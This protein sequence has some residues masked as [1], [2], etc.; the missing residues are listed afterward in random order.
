VSTGKR[1]R[2][3]TLGEPV[4]P[5]P[6]PPN[7]RPLP[8]QSDHRPHVNTQILGEWYAALVDTGAAGSFIG[9]H[10]RDKCNRHLR[11]VAPTIQSARMANGQVDT[12]TEAYWISLRI[13]TT[14]IQGKFHHLPHLPSDLV[15]GIDLLRRY[16]FSIDLKEGSASLRPPTAAD[17]VQP[18][19]PQP[20]CQVSDSPP[21]TL[22][23]DE[24]QRLRQFLTEELPLFDSVR[25][26]T[27][28]ARHE[29]RLLHPEPV[30][31]RYRPR[32]PFM[33]GIIDE[34]VD[35]MLAEGVIEPSDSPWSSPI[36]LAKKK[37]GKH[38]FC[39]DF[40]KVNE[41]TR[42]DA[43]PLPFINVILDKLRR[44]RYI[45]TIDL[46]SGYWQVPL[47]PSSKPITAFT[48]PSRG[49]YQ[50]RVMPF[51]LHSAPATFQRLMDRVIGPE[52]DPY[53]FA[54]LDDIVVLGETF[55]QHL[56][57]LQEVF[58]RLRAANLRLNPDKCQFGRRSLTYLGHVVTAAGIRTDPDKVA[59]I[60][61]LATPKTL[62]QLRRFLGMASWYRRFIPD[63]SRIAAPL[64]RLLKKGGR[65]DWTPEQDAAFNTLKDSL[66][67]APVLACPDFG[68]PFVL[69]TDA[70]DTGLGV[71]LTQYVD[72]GDHV[73]AYASRSLTKPEQAYSTTEKECLAVVWG[74]E[75]MRPYLEGYRFTVLTDHQSLKWLQAIKD[76]TGRLARW[77]IFLQQHDFD[78]RYRKGV[79]N[80]VAD[81]LSRQPAA[82]EDETTPEDLFALEGA[83]GC[84]WYNRMRQEVEKDPTVHPD[85][86]IRNERLHRHFWDMSDSTE[87]E[88]SDPWK[89]CVP[90][91]V[92][93]AVLRECH[94]NPTA[95]HL[96]IAKT[97]ARLAL[98]YYWPGM[99]R[100]AAQYV[101]NCPS[102]QR[103]KTPQQQP[104]GKMY[105]TPNRQP[106]ETV[107]T[108][109]VGPLPRSSRGNC[110]VVVMQDRFT[111]WV[112]CRAVRKATARAVTQALYEDVITRFGCP[113]TVISDN[114]T[115]YTGGTFRTLL[116]E[117]GIVH[118]LTPPY[119]PQANPV[120]RTNKTLKTMVAQFCEAD[121]KK[122]DAHLPELMFALNTSRHEST[123]YTPA[124]LNFG[125]ELVVPNAVHR[126][127][128]GNAA[129]DPPADTAADPPADP[130]ADTAADPPA[131]T[132]ADEVNEAADAVHHSERL[133][134]L[135]DTFELVRVNLARAFAKQSKHYNLRH[136]EWRCHLGDRVL[137]RD[138]PLSSGAKGFAAKL[139]P[140]YSGPYTV[141]KVLSPVVYNL[142]SPSGQKILRVHIKDLKPYRTTEPPTDCLTIFRMPN[143]RAPPAP[144]DLPSAKQ[145]RRR[146]Q[147]GQAGLAQAARRAAHQ[148]Q[149][150]LRRTPRTLQD[151]KSRARN[152]P[153]TG[154]TASGE[155][156]LLPPTRPAAS[157][158]WIDGVDRRALPRRTREPSGPGIPMDLT[159]RRRQQD[160]TPPLP[161]PRVSD[162]TP[163]TSTPT[164]PPKAPPTGILPGQA[165]QPADHPPK[166]TIA[167][168]ATTVE[169]ITALPHQACFPP[170]PA[171]GPQ[172]DRSCPGGT[173]PRRP[174]HRKVKRTRTGKRVRQYVRSEGTPQAWD[175]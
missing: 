17:E 82:T 26:L 46:K 105:P 56:Q 13:G 157:V 116:R 54:Y 10:L 3:C 156:L 75:K 47:T 111:K 62:R 99:F 142:R 2:L 43:Y 98:R 167:P 7:D 150:R 5:P 37:D 31:Q 32:N 42:K 11:P 67:A 25:G 140:K 63:F 40:R 88:L 9:D 154:P 119:T 86:C 89:L 57:V 66:S 121:Q 115:Q 18:T 48:V 106:W 147:A 95:G 84:N 149:Q 12:I 65:W 34:E 163:P 133:R 108:D 58:R 71:A 139:A 44:A 135:K 72:G 24:E 29:I 30:K 76:P 143:P 91:P 55:E 151:G 38:R 70:A 19:Q 27:P 20:A 168:T 87:P 171:A 96:G 109:L 153:Q 132:A 53:C 35:K 4:Q 59:A 83:P 61:Q 77:A 146:R 117:L 113:V 123:K 118:R 124:L 93:A 21:L 138:H 144:A 158:C 141:T 79:L 85:Y 122:W 169:G 165:L 173:R 6:T 51:G 92:R 23:P 101:R 8:E 129:A 49:L 131:D 114:G 170:A 134:L 107:S 175:P 103:Y 52:L 90:K 166:A 1:P 104:P 152:P 125:R 164:G 161:L 112:Q 78:I 160:P 22:S 97:T 28:L 120:E 33:Q 60:R 148:L 100:E 39:I 45:S 36:V 68:K 102:C 159:V 127:T 14:T 41:V 155:H 130:S 137:K 128:P 126:P 110:Y 16:P 162:R 50:F 74:I 15:L 174:R 73:I 145:Q 80:R 94:D 172:G 69:Q 64:N 81:T 136:R